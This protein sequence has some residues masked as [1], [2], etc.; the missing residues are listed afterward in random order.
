MTNI[1]ENAYSTIGA[2]TSS[3]SDGVASNLYLPQIKAADLSIDHLTIKV[4]PVVSDLP[5]KYA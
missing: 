1:Y 4:P 2:T 3:K 5:Q